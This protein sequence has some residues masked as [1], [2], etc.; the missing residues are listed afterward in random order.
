MK[1]TILTIFMSLLLFVGFSQNSVITVQGG[2]S[3]LNG[4]IGAELQFG[5][6]GISAG[7]MPTAMPLSGDPVSSYSLALSLYGKDYDESCFYGSYGIASGG[8][9]YEDTN[10]ESIVELMS[11]GMI[12]YRFTTDFG[13]SSK[14][15]AGYGWNKN[16]GVYTMEWTVGYSF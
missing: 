11:I 2:Y 14:L 4:V 3:W 9:R 13:L 6:I 8:Y 15:G 16:T 5:K 10:G 7:Y 12:G 1:K